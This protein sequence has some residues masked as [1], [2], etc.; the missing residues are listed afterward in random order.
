VGIPRCRVADPAYNAY[1]RSQLMREAADRIAIVVLFP[2][3]ELSAYTCDD[4]S[5][6][7]AVPT[8]ARL[9]RQILGRPRPLAHRC[10]D[11]MPLEVDHLLYNCAVIINRARARC[12]PEPPP[13]YREFY[14]AAVSAPG[15][16]AWPAKL[17][18]RDSR[19]PVR[20]TGFSFKRRCSGAD[21]HA[22][23]CEDLW[24]PFRRRAA[25]LAGSTVAPESFG[26]E[27][28]RVGM[29][30][31]VSRLVRVSRRDALAA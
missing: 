22:E 2:N 8:A 31:I 17:K 1:R 23:I 25:A 7:R 30:T 6:Q 9:P 3:S 14:D 5:H 15:D 29:P 26:F 21:A 16:N 24:V 27:Y 4:L 12:D 18:S 13:N 20:G 19:E 10:G 11:R 28:R